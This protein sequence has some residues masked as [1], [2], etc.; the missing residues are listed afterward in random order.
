MVVALGP[1][2]KGY[3]VYPGGQSGNPG[4]YYYDNM[5]DAWVA[6]KLNELMFLQKADSQHG[7]ILSKWEMVNDVTASLAVLL[8]NFVLQAFIYWWAVTLLTFVVAFGWGNT[9]FQSFWSGFVAV[10]ISWGGYVS[11]I[12]LQNEGILAA[13]VAALFYLPRPE[14]LILATALIGGALG[15]GGAISGYYW[16]KWLIS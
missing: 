15:G 7:Q 10:A 14:L 9:A 11:I 4:S 3:G 8:I 1:Q 13:R 5:V 6:G 12:Y 16:K 2:E